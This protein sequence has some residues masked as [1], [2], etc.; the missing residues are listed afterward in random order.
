MSLLLR[1]VR[2]PDGNTSIDPEDY[3]VFDGGHHVGRIYRIHESGR[4]RWRWGLRSAYRTADQR[5][6]GFADRLEDARDA[7]GK[8][9]SLQTVR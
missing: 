1:R 6:D 2:W 4:E 7:F 9:W 5:C 8:A 3:D